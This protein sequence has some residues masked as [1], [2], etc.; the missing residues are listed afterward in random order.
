MDPNANL[1]SQARL[2]V[3]I[4][5]LNPCTVR[6]RMQ[7]ELKEL[8]DALNQWLRKGGFE[9]DWDN[10]PF[11]AKYFKVVSVMRDGRLRTMW[12]ERLLAQ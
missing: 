6:R 10:C 7:R 3:E 11:A 4:A 2:L 5:K 1:E 12:E 8:R 9:P